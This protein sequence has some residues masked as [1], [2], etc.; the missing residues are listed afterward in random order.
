MANEDMHIVYNCDEG[1][2]PYVAVSM[3]SLLE[4]NR[5]AEGIHIHLLESGLSKKTGELLS[6]MVEA[7]GP[8]RRLELVDISDM[9]QRL[10]GLTDAYLLPS[11]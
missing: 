4:N 10:R 1:F 11:S 5:D 2:A 7:Y 8:T 3:V 6:S 9:E